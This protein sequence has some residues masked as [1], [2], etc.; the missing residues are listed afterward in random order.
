M[1]FREELIGLEVKI[2]YNKKTFEGI[3]VDET[4][5]M[6]HL[7]TKKDIKKLIKKNLIIY[8]NDKKIKGSKIQKRPEE[9]IKM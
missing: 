3:I 7:K 1:K 9:R 4:K 8:T 5:N 2:Q 6:I